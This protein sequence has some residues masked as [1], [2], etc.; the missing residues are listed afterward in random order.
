MKLS[1]SL[2]CGIGVLLVCL[3][4]SPQSDTDNKEPAGTPTAFIFGS[5]P[6]ELT[7][8]ASK[9][10]VVF[11][12]PA[13]PLS[14]KSWT[15]F[16]AFAMKH[17]NA[18]PIKNKLGGLVGVEGR[19]TFVG[20]PYIVSPKGSFIPVVDPIESYFEGLV[21][22]F[23][24]GG[25]PFVLRGQPAP[26]GGSGGN[27]QEETNQCDL[28]RT[29]CSNYSSWNDHYIIFN[30][31]GSRTGQTVGGYVQTLYICP[32]TPDCDELFTCHRVCWTASGSNTL[33]VGNF[34]WQLPD[35][36]TATA[37]GD[38][39]RSNVTGVTSSNWNILFNAG[40]ATNFVGVCAVHTTF[41][42]TPRGQT[43]SGTYIQDECPR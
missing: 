4:A 29:A 25:L 19:L 17:L 39:T 28:A 41:P 31:V 24:V 43:G 16:A 13:A 9:G 35:N 40:L 5:H 10:R 20:T 32:P 2:S 37:Q 14:F 42:S 38:I 21:G 30:S 26:F 27:L 1:K 22:S 7:V 36:P 33:H 15:T 34:F 3:N 8:D 6:G 18:K 23:Y 12:A 11:P